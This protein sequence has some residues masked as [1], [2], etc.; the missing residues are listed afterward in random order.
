MLLAVV[1]LPLTAMPAAAS[2]YVKARA[3][4]G[5][6]SDREV[7]REVRRV[8]QQRGFHKAVTTGMK[9]TC[10]RRSRLR[11]QCRYSRRDV[12]AILLV[13]GN[14]SVSVTS[15]ARG[16]PLR[17][18]LDTTVT[19]APPCEDS[20]SGSCVERYLFTQATHERVDGTS[21][22][23]LPV[24]A[25]TTTQT[26]A[27]NGVQRTY[28]KVVPERIDPDGPAPI[29]IGFHGGND[30]AGNANGYMGLTSSARCCT[31]TPRAR[32]SPMRG[33]A[34]MSMSPERTSRSWMLCSPT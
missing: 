19:F 33:Q 29:V 6:L 21:G 3:K 27:V 12:G 22:C 34:G 11:Y 1:S 7:R 26:I 15:L 18:R 25:G 24:T 14:G 10:R 9:Q 16:A 17:Y 4:S 30:T 23:G 2:H 31:S 8:L 32:R 5:P 13:R 28:L 20:Q